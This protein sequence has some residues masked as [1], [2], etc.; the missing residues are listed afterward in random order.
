M[1][2][3]FSCDTLLRVMSAIRWSCSRFSLSKRSALND[4]W[5]FLLEKGTELRAPMF[6]FIP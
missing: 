4:D 5:V 1:A 3:P 2:N 6:F